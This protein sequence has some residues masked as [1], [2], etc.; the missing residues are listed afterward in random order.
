MLCLNG[1]YCQDLFG[2]EPEPSVGD[3][4]KPSS[5]FVDAAVRHLLSSTTST[6]WVPTLPESLLNE[7]PFTRQKR[8]TNTADVIISEIFRRL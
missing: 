6:K 2:P 3:F 5:T 1:F 8:E 7:M 4:Q